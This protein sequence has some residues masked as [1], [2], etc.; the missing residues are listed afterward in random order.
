[1]A[2]K[3]SRTF[4]APNVGP[5]VRSSTIVI[6]AI[7]APARNNNA[8]LCASAGLPAPVMRKLLPKRD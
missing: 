1:M 6:G 3:P 4:S 7:K 8:K 5:T 2:S